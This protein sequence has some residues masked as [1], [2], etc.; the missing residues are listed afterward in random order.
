MRKGRCGP[1]ATLEQCTIYEPTRA[2]DC[3][4]DDS[5]GTFINVKLR[6][7]ETYAL[8]LVLERAIELRKVGLW[9]DPWGHVTAM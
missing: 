9:E 2:F 8:E 7:A 5:D 4:F 6:L 1:E 3:V